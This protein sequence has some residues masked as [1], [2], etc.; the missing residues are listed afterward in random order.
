MARPSRPRSVADRITASRPS[1]SGRRG[2]RRGVVAITALALLLP[3]SVAAAIEPAPDDLPQDPRVDV[4]EQVVDLTFPVADPDT[5]VTYVDDFLY[6]RGGGTRLHAATDIM[7]PKHR[8]V[9]AAVGGVVSWAPYEPGASGYSSLG[10]PHYGWM[11]S[12]RGDD[13][14]RY[15]YVHLNNDTPERGSD[16]RWLDDDA[17]GVDHAYAP[18]IAEAVKDKGSSLHASDGVRVERGELIG[19]V[20]DSGNAKGGEPH[21]HLEIELTDDDGEPY[22][23]NPYYSLNDALDRGDVP[24]GDAGS[25]SGGDAPDEDEEATDDSQDTSDDRPAW[26]DVLAGEAHTGAIER[27]TEAGIVRGCDDGRYC[28]SADVT[29]DDIAAAITAALELDTDAALARSDTGY[30][31]VAGDH[32]DAGA[33]VAVREA[34]IMQGYGDGRFGPDSAFTRAQLATVLVEAFELPAATSAPPFGDIA[35]DDPHAT[36]I[37]AAWDA[38]LTQGCG[39]GD[40]YCGS[41]HVTRGQIASFLEAGM[42]FTP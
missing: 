20:G 12:I 5:D 18:R 31:D 30:L 41:D 3:T 25:G 13:G 15:S 11:L 35:D 39:S 34:G 40:G 2:V 22:R 32:P 4:T 21:L 26:S 17:G 23:I 24:G 29:R 33:I 36:A 9:H 19:W 38:G 6:L 14:R 27:L 37:A 7:A 42:A 8:P 16:D 1:A 10:E 28:P